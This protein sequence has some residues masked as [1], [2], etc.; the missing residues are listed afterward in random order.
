MRLMTEQFPPYC[1]A[2]AL[3]TRITFKDGLGPPRV[4]AGP[5]LW[6]QEK[7]DQP[8]AVESWT[9]EV[10]AICT[11]QCHPATEQHVDIE[12]GTTWPEPGHYVSNPFLPSGD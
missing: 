6:V 7:R 9:T 4:M 10:T 11:R 12:R 8:A 3:V 5:P 2:E 1:G